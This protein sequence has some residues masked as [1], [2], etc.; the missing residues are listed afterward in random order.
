MSRREHDRQVHFK[1][2]YA[3]PA[4]GGK[5]TNLLA[6]YERLPPEKRG[7]LLSLAGPEER[8]DPRRQSIHD[9]NTIPLGEV[10]AADELP[11][12]V[13]AQRPAAPRF[14]SMLF[15]EPEQNA[16]PPPVMDMPIPVV[17]KK[18]VKRTEPLP[19]ESTG[20]KVSETRKEKTNVGPMPSIVD[21]RSGGRVL[22]DPCD[23]AFGVRR[24]HAHRQTLGLEAIDDDV[25]EDPSVDPPHRPQ[26][27]TAVRLDQ[28]Q[29]RRCPVVVAARPVH[30]EAHQRQE[31]VAAD[32]L[33]QLRLGVTEA[34]QVRL[35]E[36]DAAHLR[37]LA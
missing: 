30:L 33:P 22:P 11:P 28:L 36:V 15:P 34:A 3:G 24:V 20:L 31:R 32:A 37:V 14:K 12:P 29:Q 6:L 8:T 16:P 9:Q 19:T 23:V 13:D 18:K 26:A 25:V 35:R 10:P 21:V 2:V 17:K 4:L 1:I 27:G 7:R 5:T